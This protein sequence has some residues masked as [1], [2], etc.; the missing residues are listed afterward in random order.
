MPALSETIESGVCF[1]EH[2]FPLL[3]LFLE[4]HQSG[5]PVDAIP[6]V[7]ASLSATDRTE[8]DMFIDESDSNFI[9]HDS[10]FQTDADALLNILLWND[11]PD[12]YLMNLL[13]TRIRKDLFRFDDTL[14]R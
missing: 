11:L 2:E 12:M 3:Q 5:F 8:K 10:D 9:R 7:D 14:R 1:V 4:F 6:V 13:I